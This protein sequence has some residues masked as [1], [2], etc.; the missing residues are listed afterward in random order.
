MDIDWDKFERMELRMRIIEK[1]IL[2]AILMY[3]VFI[4]KE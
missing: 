3:N 1:L 2:L 4:I